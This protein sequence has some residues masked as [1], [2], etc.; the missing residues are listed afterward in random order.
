MIHLEAH[1]LP[2]PQYQP[3]ASREQTSFPS[4]ALKS[5]FKGIYWQDAADTCNNEW[6]NILSEA[7][8][9][10]IPYTEVDEWRWY[11]GAAW[12]RFFV[13]P[14][15]AKQG[16]SWHVGLNSRFYPKTSLYT[17]TRT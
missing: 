15:K 13:S 3:L 8:R 11:E 16:R 10:L 12:N 14:A 1:A 17:N 9:M 2:P 7:T 6:Q 5:N 4:T